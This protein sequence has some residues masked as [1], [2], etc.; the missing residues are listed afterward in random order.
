M[1]R[2]PLVEGKNLVALHGVPWQ[3][4]FGGVF[5]TDTSVLPPGNIGHGTSV[6]FGGT[7][8]HATIAMSESYHFNSSGQWVDGFDHDVTWKYPGVM[9]NG[10][11]KWYK[12]TVANNVTN[13]FRVDWNAS[14]GETETSLGT[15]APALDTEF[16]SRG[17]MIVIPDL[18]TP[19]TPAFTGFRVNE[20]DKYTTATNKAIDASGHFGPYW[21]WHWSFDW[22]PILKVPTTNGTETASTAPNGTQKGTFSV[23]VQGAGSGTDSERY[24][25]VSLNMPVAMHPRD[26]G[27]VLKD[28]AGGQTLTN[29]NGNAVGRFHAGDGMLSGDAIYLWD[30]EAGGVR[31]GNVVYY[32]G[33]DWKMWQGS[34]PY[35]DVPEGFFKPGDV[36]IIKSMS[37]GDWTWTYSPTYDMPTRHMGR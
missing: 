33:T 28:S 7:Q 1:N 6:E 11:R 9:A 34:N 29:R 19:D 14:G 37:P 15:S 36:I 22:Y 32:N 10:S 3:N 24:T 12:K 18:D 21:N 27:L 17:F 26:M 25:L 2:V 30:N 8:T 5:G 23:K 4:T 13:W 35:A 20:N 16:F 31:D